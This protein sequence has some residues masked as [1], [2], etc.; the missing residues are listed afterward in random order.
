MRLWP[1][2]YEEL[3]RHR[4]EGGRII[5]MADSRESIVFNVEDDEVSAAA[6]LGFKSCRL[7]ISM[8]RDFLNARRF[9]QSNDVVVCF[10]FPTA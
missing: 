3:V 5:Y 10:Y 8:L 7:L 2:A 4:E 9:E 6:V 1:H